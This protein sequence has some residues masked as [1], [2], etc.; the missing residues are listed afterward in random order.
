VPDQAKVQRIYD[1]TVELAD[2]IDEYRADL[3]RELARHQER[4]QPVE[5]QVDK[6]AVVV[7]DWL[8]PA[9]DSMLALLED[10]FMP[11]LNRIYN[12][13]AMMSR[14]NFE[15]DIIV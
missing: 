11:Y 9:C 2:L 13:G 8:V 6:L 5:G 3:R 14:P 4:A 15:Q 7:D 1:L 12:T 10:D